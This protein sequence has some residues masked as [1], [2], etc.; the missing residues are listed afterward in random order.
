MIPRSTCFRFAA[1]LALIIPNIIRAES[2][3]RRL[4]QI[5]IG[6]AYPDRLAQ[7]ADKSKWAAVSRHAGMIIHPDNLKPGTPALEITKSVAPH[8]GMRRAIVERNSL[9][10]PEDIPAR[11]AMARETLGFHDGVYFYFNG[12]TASKNLKKD[13]VVPPDPAWWDRARLARE[14]G[15]VPL[16]GP[17]PHVLCRRPAGWNDPAWD[18]LRDLNVFQGYCFDAPAELY[19]REGKDAAG[20]ATS[21]RYR[22]SVV[23][24]VRHA[25]SLDRMSIYLFSAHGGAEENIA[26]AREVVRDLKRRDALPTAWAIEDYTRDSKLPMVPELNAEGMPAATVTGLAYWILGFYSGKF[27]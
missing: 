22:E 10:K 21:E 20:R 9:P 18:F 23:Q 15:A 3:P 14:H 26:R 4:P 16:Y 8:F 1:I 6:A 19:L 24:A 12:I 7:L 17:A 2:E 25:R 5:F 11:I 27:Q 13:G